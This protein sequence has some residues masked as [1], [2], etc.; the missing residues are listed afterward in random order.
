[1]IK[2]NFL[3]I[4]VGLPASGKSTF[5]LKLKDIIEIKL[6]PYKTKIIDPDMI[7]N[8]ITYE[9]FDYKKESI[10]RKK[11]LIEVRQS[12]KE[13][14]I[15]ISD[16][17]N[18]YSSMRHDLK[19]IAE[20]QEL[21]YFIIHLT[22]PLHVC[23]KWNKIRGKPIPNKVIKKIYNKLDSFDKYSWDYPVVE[24]DPSQ[25]QISN[26][27]IDEILVQIINKLTLQLNSLPK[28]TQ[29]ESKSNVD[30]EKLDM[31]TRKVVGD[32]L[33]DPIYKSLKNQIIKARKLFIKQYPNA[34]FNELEISKDFKKF[35]N[36]FL[37]QARK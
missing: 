3:I 20:N 37:R 17:L 34:S 26:E 4:L 13:H 28:I 21:H 31:A 25:Y 36:G 6:K 32:L 35:L 22:T 23:L 9:K 14:F 2:N 7:R 10:V 18:Y 19:E 27:K 33:R 1:L 12:L 30:N 8:S 24:Y 15:V 5:A 16:D 11:N 29:I